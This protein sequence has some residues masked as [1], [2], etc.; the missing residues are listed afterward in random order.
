MLSLDTNAALQ[1]FLDLAAIPGLSGQ[2][3]A[4]MT[5]IIAM[6]TNAGV[7]SAL[8][9]FDDA[10]TRTMIGGEIGNLI[11]RI[12][13]TISG[14]TT[15][16][17]AHTDTV[18]ICVGSEPFVDGDQVR[19]RNA[20]TGLGADD[21][22]G[23]AAMVTAVVELLKSGRPYA[24]ITL[25]FCV[26]EEIGLYGARYLNREV[27]GHVDRAFNFDGGAVEKL[28]CGA[29][30][31]EKMTINVHGIPAHAGVSPQAGASAI[32]IAANAISA[33]HQTGWLGRIEKAGSGVGTANIGV[34]NGGDATNV[35]TPLV[36]LRAEARSHDPMMRKRIVTEIE[37]AFQSAAASLTNNAG[38]RGR[39]EFESRVD[40][41]SFALPDDDPSIIAGE[42]AVH[43]VGRSPHR[44]ISD[45]GLD[46]NWLFRHGI[47]AVTLGC[48][49]HN[50]H[51]SDERLIIADYLDSCRIALHLISS[52]AEVNA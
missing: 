35:V 4:V 31:G 9:Q 27:L 40:Y 12:P 47:P 16:L 5:R 7:D 51:T 21:R 14:P 50:I 3:H 44:K 26:Q 19:S 23:C 36:T 25:L 41:E 20:S 17:S 8:F 11:V 43:A 48:G 45:G 34:I 29:I 38:L 39:I 49:Q 24:P 22:S 33:L 28:T 42:A 46:A 18:P 2:E 30:G 15:M 10:N 37:T 13:G 52:S 6:L 32:V 1:R